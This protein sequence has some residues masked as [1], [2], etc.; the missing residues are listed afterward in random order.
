MIKCMADMNSNEEGIIVNIKNT[1][2]SSLYASLGITIGSKVI[3]LYKG[4]YAINDIIFVFN[5]GDK[6]NVQIKSHH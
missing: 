5:D 6:V 4:Y 2:S 1:Y 3:C